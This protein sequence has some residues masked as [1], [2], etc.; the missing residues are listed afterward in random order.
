MKYYLGER[1]PEGCQVAVLDGDGQKG[2]PLDP[3]LDL[4][5]HSPTF[6][7]G[8]WSQSSSQLAL[9]ILADALGDDHRALRFS[10]EFKKQILA[11]LPA[12]RWEL[13]QANILRHL[14]A[15][16]ARPARAR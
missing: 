8:D 16:Q 10:E 6:N 3:R 1:T 7:W 2:Y 5:K 11:D 4:A 12:D 15:L 13:S 14:M 9:A